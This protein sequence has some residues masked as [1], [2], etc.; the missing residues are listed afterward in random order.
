VANNASQATTA[1]VTFS[2]VSAVSQKVTICHRTHS[3]TNPY[4]RITATM[5]SS[6]A[7]TFTKPASISVPRTSFG[8]TSFLPTP[9]AL[10]VGPL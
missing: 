10:L 2:I 9:L 6:T 7:S 1:T 3:E 5:R 4:V 8:A